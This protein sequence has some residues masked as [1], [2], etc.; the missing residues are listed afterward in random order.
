MFQE[1]I[2]ELSEAIA[3]HERE[4]KE[5]NEKIAT[6]ERRVFI[7][8]LLLFIAF[9]SGL[10][11]L[12]FLL[13][14]LGRTVPTTIY[15]L[16]ICLAAVLGSSA[17]LAYIAKSGCYNKIKELISDIEQF[18]SGIAYNTQKIEQINREIEQA[19]ISEERNRHLSNEMLKINAK[20]SIVASFIPGRLSGINDE[21][22]DARES[23]TDN[24]YAPFWD[25]IEKAMSSIDRYYDCIDELR[26]LVE[27]YTKCTSEYKPKEGEVVSFPINLKI[28]SSFDKITELERKMQNMI[29]PAQSNIDFASI[30]EM[31]R[32]SQILVAGFQNLS[33]AIYGLGDTLSEQLSSLN[34]EIFS[35][36]EVIDSSAKSISSTVSNSSLVQSELMI[37]NNALQKDILYEVNK[38]RVN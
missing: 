16:V 23:F 38:I 15:M 25:N 14:H 32:T 21:L 5:A 22:N 8:N 7:G 12:Y 35:L 29:R 28:V 36:G 26:K 27:D 11:I 17:L 2:I 31:R 1:K 13:S 10:T 37:K 3:T 20:A 6:V 24:L 4:I 34:S 9:S 33:S 19:K 18:S 30:Y